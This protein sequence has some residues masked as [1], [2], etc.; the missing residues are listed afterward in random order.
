MRITPPLGA[1]GVYELR[2]PWTVSSTVIY[3]CMAVRTIPELR[4][5]GIDPFTEF[6]SGNLVTREQYDKDVA[7]G[8]AIV[9]LLSESQE[10]IHV[11]DTFIIKF[12]FEELVP[13]DRVVLSISLGALP[14]SV[15]LEL[16]QAKVSEVA[17]GVIGVEAK[18]A[19]HAAP[20]MGAVTPEQ[21][22]LN[23]LARNAAVT[24]RTTTL[25]QLIEAQEKI[26]RLEVLVKAYERQAIL[27]QTKIE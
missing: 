27:A 18:V 7:E 2:A 20:S 24:D 17:S 23:E 8:V 4:E 26:S 21:A 11:P 10:A 19:I 12:P 6:Y 22:K 3:R 16:L 13:Y 1:M 15:P 9:T 5:A 25:A 14:A